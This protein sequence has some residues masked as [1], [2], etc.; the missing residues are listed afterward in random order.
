MKWFKYHLIF[1]FRAYKYE[2]FISLGYKYEFKK[3]KLIISTS[4]KEYRT[5]ILQSWRF[6]PKL[7]F[8]FYIH[9]ILVY[10]WELCLI[11]RKPRVTWHLVNVLVWFDWIVNLNYPHICQL[12][13]FLS[14]L[15][16]TALLY[17]TGSDSQKEMKVF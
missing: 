4:D 7:C 9:C 11:L 2:H 10:V 3:W 15:S 5:L 12:S 14:S 6:I 13:Y 8:W 1:F 17:C 16:L